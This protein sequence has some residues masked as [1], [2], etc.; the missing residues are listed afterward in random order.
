MEKDILYRYFAGNATD[1]ERAQI[2]RWVELSPDNY[3]EF[4]KERRMF[5]LTSMLIDEVA[6]A[7]TS[8]TSTWR[9]GRFAKWAGRAAAA[10]A[11]L[12]AGAG[13][14]RIAVQTEPEAAPMNQ[15]SV[16]AG[17]RLNLVLSDGSDVW[18]G[19]NSTIKFPGDFRGDSRRVELDGEAF[20]S[21]AQ[22]K[23]RP[24]HVSTSHG[25]VVVTGTK[26]NIDAYSASSDY[27]VTLTEGS[28]TFVCESGSYALEPGRRIVGKADGSIAFESTQTNTPDW[29]CG[30]VSFHNLPFN[31]IMKR[32]EKYYGVEI[33]FIRPDIAHECFSGKFYIDDGIEQ[34][35]NTLKHD[36]KFD[37]DIDRDFRH[38]NIK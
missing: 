12:V 22:N 30:I 1:D 11:L 24:F 10:V 18:L 7:E 8:N 35:L 3:S 28:V 9:I 29:V 15:I 37:Y 27:S 16:P 36:I 25:E 2:R 21:V 23:Q 26:F 20:F 14:G 32:F 19:S 4:I 33:D 38:I 34:A 5:D 17:Q 6:P 13:I 31:D